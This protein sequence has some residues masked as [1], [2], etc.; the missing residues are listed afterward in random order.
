MMLKFV[1]L[2]VLV[3]AAF[4]AP[5]CGCEDSISSLEKRIEVLEAKLG[6]F[7]HNSKF[8][9]VLLCLCL[10]L[11]FCLLLRVCCLF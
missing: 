1:A 10:L 3:A 4:A 6:S 8:L 7:S 9:F 11:C 5:P 2:T